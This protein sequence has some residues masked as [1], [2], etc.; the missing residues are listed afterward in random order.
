MDCYYARDWAGALAKFR[1]SAELEPNIPG[2]T[3]GVSSNPS[4][5]YQEITAHWQIEPPPDNWGGEYVM[6][7]K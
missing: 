7:E 3:P 5:V 2:K 4:L 1:Q 6:K